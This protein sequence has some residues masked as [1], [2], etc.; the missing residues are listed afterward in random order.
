MKATALVASAMAAL[1]VLGFAATAGSAA[2]DSATVIK[3][4]AALMKQQGGD[5]G[6]V[7]AFLDGKAPKAKAVAAATDLTQT[8]LK[9][10]GLFPAGSGGTSPDGKFATKPAIWSDWQ[11]FLAAQGNGSAKAD[12]LA[13][14]FKTNDKKKIAAAFGDLGKNGCGGCHTKFREQLQK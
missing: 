5:M 13:A 7:H 12:A 4:R 8:M 2:D 10:P 11:G 14:A 3:E 1:V 9:I 6:A